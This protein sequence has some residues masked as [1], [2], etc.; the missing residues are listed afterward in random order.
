MKQGSFWLFIGLILGLSIGLTY[1]WLIDPVQYY[2]TMPSMLRVDY[3][4]RWIRLSM[5]VHGIE[6]DRERTQLRLKHIPE[7]TLQRVLQETFEEA[8]RSGYPLPT[9]KRMAELAQSYG[10]DT[11]AVR[12][13]TDSD[14]LSL[15]PRPTEEPET[16]VSPTTAP[17]PT[18]LP[19]ET[20]TLMPTP[21][22]VPTLTPSPS[23]FPSPT[24]TP[25]PSLT[26]TRVFTVPYQLAKRV[27]LCTA[28]PLI[29][30]TVAE[31]I[32]QTVRGRERLERVG[33]PGV[34]IWLLWEDGADHAVTG[35]RPTQG[36]GYADFEVMPEQTYNLYIEAP[37]GIPMASLNVRRC[38]NA[39]GEL[40]W[41]GWGLLVLKQEGGDH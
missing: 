6:G 29:T 27:S 30:I 37:I 23:P 12:I 19:T 26:P 33:L 4:E 17:S 20:P 15:T 11:A 38:M 40:A 8:V 31:E 21:T 2:D 16:V 36:L 32:T 9:L 41:T 22:P 18:A 14:A 10:I 5:F 34:Q 39:D 1:A 35:F 25:L 28:R 7:A 3:Q 24:L 13:Y